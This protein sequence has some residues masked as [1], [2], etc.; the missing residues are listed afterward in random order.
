[1][2]EVFFP[3]LT[4]SHFALV[5]NALH[6]RPNVDSLYPPAPQTLSAER[7]IWKNGPCWLRTLRRQ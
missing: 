7:E 4:I 5:K 1:M 3:I 6:L 2:F